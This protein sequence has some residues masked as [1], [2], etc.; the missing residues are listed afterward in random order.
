[1]KTAT[2]QTNQSTTPVCVTA[3]AKDWV[4]AV[5]AMRPAVIT[6]R[7]AFAGS[8]LTEISFADGRPVLHSN[9]F[10]IAAQRELIPETLGI[11]KPG[12]TVFVQYSWMLKML[13]L[14]ARKKIHRSHV[15]H[16]QGHC[17]ASERRLLTSR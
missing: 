9:Y 7:K 4:E 17:G 3:P 6:G 14:L 5:E 11:T 8:E 1:M 10:D 13:K 2:I 16:G 15:N 12:C